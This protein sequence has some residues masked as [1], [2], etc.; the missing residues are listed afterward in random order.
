MGMIALIG[1]SL[2]D[3]VELLPICPKGGECKFYRGSNDNLLDE[4]N[5]SLAAMPREVR[6]RDGELILLHNKQSGTL[7]ARA[8]HLVTWDRYGEVNRHKMSTLHL[9]PTTLEH[10][11]VRVDDDRDGRKLYIAKYSA[12]SLHCVV[13]EPKT[14][15]H[16]PDGFA[17]YLITQFPYDPR[18][19]QRFL[20]VEWA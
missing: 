11:A 2:G 9:V 12:D 3:V 1:R 20:R 6:A 16:P 7:R 18:G 19:R 4:A 5:R 14:I 15:R 13:I 17:G 10:C 8:E